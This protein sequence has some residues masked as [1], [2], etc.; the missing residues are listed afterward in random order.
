MKDSDDVLVDEEMKSSDDILVDE[1]NE[2]D[3]D[4]LMFRRT[5]LMLVSLDVPAGK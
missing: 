1:G 5:V 3:N 4:L 2:S